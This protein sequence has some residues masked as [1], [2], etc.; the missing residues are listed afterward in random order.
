[1]TF[2]QPPVEIIRGSDDSSLPLTAYPPTEVNLQVLI[3]FPDGYERG[4]VRSYLLIND[5]LVLE[6]VAPP[7]DS[8]TWDIANLLEPGVYNLQV[9]VEDELGLQADTVIHRIQLAVNIP[10]S[11][12][13]A[14]GAGAWLPTKR[15]PSADRRHCQ[16][17]GRFFAWIR[18]RTRDQAPAEP[19]A[20]SESYLQSPVKSAE[21]IPAGAH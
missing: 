5:E 12:I 18:K 7:Y 4:I 10:P 15:I 13:A 16:R 20:R 3:D 1:M 21:R 19:H 8:F 6:Q 14:L 9:H 11:G 17:H 2:I